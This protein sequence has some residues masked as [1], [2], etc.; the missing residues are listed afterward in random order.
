MLV[1]ALVARRHA[2]LKRSWLAL[3]ERENLEG[4]AAVHV[5]SDVEAAEL[6]KFDLRLRRV[7]AIPNGAEVTVAPIALDPPAD[8]ARLRTMHPLILAFGRL[9]WTKQLDRLIEAF[10]RTRT[11]SLAIVGTDDEG[12]APVLGKLAETLGV[13]ERVHL[14]PRTVT[15]AE[16][17]F[18]FAAARGLVLASLSESFGNV[19]IEAMQRGL[20][21]IAAST[22]GVSE[23]VVESGGGIVVGADPGE[24]AAAIARLF[25]DLALATRL[26]AA[27]REFVEKHCGWDDVAERMETLYRSLLNAAEP[28]R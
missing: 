7:V 28:G 23:I 22:T 16:K 11:G 3:I 8:I 14:V 9:S 24:L 17:E 1:K 15:G 5:T 10:A 26:G 20:P 19:A 21:V 25:G 27:G 13:A 6:D 12:L 18:V 2:L 4:A